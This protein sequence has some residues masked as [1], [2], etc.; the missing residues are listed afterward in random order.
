MYDLPNA[1]SNV[2][3]EKLT[4]EES[5]SVMFSQLYAIT[6][7]PNIFLAFVGGMLVTRIGVHFMVILVA[8]FV[9]IGQSIFTISGFQAT[10]DK[11]NSSPYFVALIGRFVFGIGKELLVVWQITILSRYFKNRELSFAICTFYSCTW[12]AIVACNYLISQVY[13][14]TTSLGFWLLICSFIWFI[15][16][17]FGI[18]FV[19]I[20]NH[21]SWSNRNENLHSEE[22]HWNDVK[23]LNISFWVI[24]ISWFWINTEFLFSM[25]TNDFMI[26]RYGLNQIEAGKITATSNI[27]FILFTPLC[28]YLTDKYGYR[29]TSIMVSSSLLLWVHILWNIIPSAVEHDKSFYGYIPMIV[30]NIASPIYYAG[31]FSMIPIVVKHSAHG[32]AFGICYS[33]INW[34]NV[35]SPIVVGDLTFYDQ[36]VDAYFWTH[37]SL[38][39]FS[40]MGIISSII[41]YVYNKLY[42]NNILQQPSHKQEDEVQLLD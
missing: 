37:I 20:D 9:F 27:I 17:I 28:G 39:S 38:G 33:F 3:F 21:V 23:V 19:I 2:M 36:G 14:T 24:M 13:S 31:M 4:H 30:Y 18:V 32:T 34:A 25:I 10:D 5:T 40:F 35:L 11:E 15:S 41:I 12:S 16:V 26:T 42:L 7:L 22:F 1:L 29:V 6:N 8:M